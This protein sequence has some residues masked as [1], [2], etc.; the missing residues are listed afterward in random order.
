MVLFN[1]LP[2]V[3][4]RW[5]RYWA[6]AYALLLAVG[7]VVLACWPHMLVDPAFLVL[8]G[9]YVVLLGKEGIK[10]RLSVRR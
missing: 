8:A 5:R 9:S 1:P 4:W 3:C 6:L 2:L 10:S 7:T